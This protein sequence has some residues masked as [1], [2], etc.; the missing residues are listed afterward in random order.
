LISTNAS[1]SNAAANS[2]TTSYFDILQQPAI[3][4]MMVQSTDFYY[5]RKYK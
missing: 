2:F 1:L 4:D 3:N 5:T